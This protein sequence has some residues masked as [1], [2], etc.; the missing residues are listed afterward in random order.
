MVSIGVVI[1]LTEVQGLM[2]V[3]YYCYIN[4]VLLSII[5][6]LKCYPI[7]FA[8]IN[9]KELSHESEIWV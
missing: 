4:I 2:G 1:E 3:W 6:Q 9:V 8:S 7:Y 5:V